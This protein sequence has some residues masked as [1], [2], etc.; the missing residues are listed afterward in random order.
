LFVTQNDRASGSMEN[1]SMVSDVK[2]DSVYGDLRFIKERMCYSTSREVAN[3]PPDH[4]RCGK[5]NGQ[6]ANDPRRHICG[7][8]NNCF[9]WAA[10]AQVRFTSQS[11]YPPV[12]HSRVFVKIPRGYPRSTCLD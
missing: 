12:A 10:D 8:R 9:Q 4:T 2:I 3:K 1:H 11:L 7:G 6:C 5:R